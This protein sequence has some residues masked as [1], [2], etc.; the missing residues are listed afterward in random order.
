MICEEC[1]V[2]LIQTECAMTCPECGN[3]YR[4][5]QIF[6]GDMYNTRLK[7]RQKT[8][9]SRT[10]QFELNLRLLQGIQAPPLGVLELIPTEFKTMKELVAL[11][12]KNKL[13]K[14]SKYKYYFWKKI[15]GEQLVHISFDQQK[16]LKGGYVD[17][18]KRFFKIDKLNVPNFNFVMKKL[19]TAYGYDDI[20]KHI[21]DPVLKRTKRNNDTTW[22]LLYPASDQPAFE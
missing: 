21:P 19:C 7:Y 10:K 16:K 14:Y 22:N 4:F 5:N 9:Y 17:I 15:K 8:I 3:C 11:L 20:L 6:I 12:K 2:S 1:K 13:S 18:L